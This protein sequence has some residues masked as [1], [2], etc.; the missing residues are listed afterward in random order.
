MAVLR[1]K[2]H[3]RDQ[4]GP[5]CID[6]PLCALRHRGRLPG[7]DAGTDQGRCSGQSLKEAAHERRDTALCSRA[8]RPERWRG[9]TARLALCE[10][11]HA[12][13]PA[14]RRMPI[15]TAADRAWRMQLRG[16]RRAGS[17]SVADFPPPPLHRYDKPFVPY[18]IGVVDLDCSLRVVGQMV[19]PPSALRVGDTVELVIRALPRR[20]ARRSHRGNSGSSPRPRQGVSDMQ[21]VAVLG[22][23]LHRFGKTGDDIVGNKSVTALCRHAIDAALSDAGVPWKQIQ[24][25]CAASSRFSGGKGWGLNGN[26]VV[27]ELGS[28]GIPVYNMSA[29]CAAGGNAFNV[30]YSMV[31]GGVYDMVLVVGGEVMPKGMI[32]TSGVEEATDPEF[33]RQPVSACPA[34]RSGPRSRPPAHARLRHHGRAVREGGGEGAQV[35]LHNPYARFQKE[36]GLDEVLPS[37]TSAIRCDSSRYARCPTWRRSRGDLLGGKGAPVHIAAVLSRIQHGG[38]DALQRCAAA[39]ARRPGARR[40]QLPHRIARRGETGV[41][42]GGHRSAGREPHGVA[43]QHLLLR[44]SRTPRNGARTKPGEA[45]RLLESDR[46]RRTVACRSTLRAASCPSARPRRQWACSRSSN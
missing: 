16:Q 14:I 6:L 46:P 39:R 10:L 4:Q 17:Y 33:L 20:T 45:E 25:V 7:R 24:A 43:G 30:G 34:R 32:Q 19:D 40:P 44:G 38:D 2:D 41:R 36:I 5:R 35:F 27:E 11:P 37:P 15:P 28:T 22:V 31:A 23:G 12:L 8:V 21:E 26:D 13:F 42:D 18:A 3:R 1:R 29:G 9:A